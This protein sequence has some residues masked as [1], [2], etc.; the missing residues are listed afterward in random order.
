MQGGAE[1]EG[2]IDDEE[3]RAGKAHRAG[4]PGQGGHEGA[5]TGHAD[6]DQDGVGDRAKEAEPE[7]VSPEQALAQDK[8]VLRADGEDD[9]K[10]GEKSGQGRDHA[11]FLAFATASA[12]AFAAFLSAG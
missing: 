10:A 11:V 9:G 5:E 12:L 8:C 2:A 4:E 6:D 7:N 3:R 1:A